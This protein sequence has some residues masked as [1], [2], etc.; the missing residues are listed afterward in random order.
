[1]AT[2]SIQDRTATA[3]MNRTSGVRGALRPTLNVYVFIEKNKTSGVLGIGK[4]SGENHGQLKVIP[5]T[6][7]EGAKLVLYIP[8]RNKQVDLTDI[9]LSE[10]TRGAHEGKN[11]IIV[12]TPE[13]GAIYIR[14]CNDMKKTIDETPCH[15]GLTLDMIVSFMRR[16]QHLASSVSSIS[17][18]LQRSRARDA[19]AAG[20]IVAQRA[21]ILAIEKEE[22]K[23]AAENLASLEARLAAAALKK[24]G[25]K[26]KRTHKNKGNKKHRR[27]QKGGKKR[28]KT[29]KGKGRKSRKNRSKKH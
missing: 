29:Q 6:E 24:K 2:D 14:P 26:R 9:N 19:L 23:E 22:K 20:E 4:K 25:G 15:T 11:Y 8:T 7:S 1:M 21:D 3:H 10:I 12:N 18:T 27:T 17:D 16:T 13:L 5:A 28:R